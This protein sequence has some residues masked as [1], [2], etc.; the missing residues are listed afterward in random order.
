MSHIEMS[1]V[2]EHKDVELV[3]ADMD[4]LID[5]FLDFLEKYTLMA[6]TVWTFRNGPAEPIVDL[7]EGQS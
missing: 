4:D 1:A 6:S 3:Q 7:L 2:I 5:G